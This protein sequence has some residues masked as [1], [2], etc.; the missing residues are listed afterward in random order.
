[1]NA[2]EQLLKVSRRVNWSIG[3]VVE[4]SFQFNYSR[5]FLPEAL[6]AA[7]LPFLSADEQRALNQIRAHG[8]LCLFRLAEEFILPFVLDYA[9]DNRGEDDAETQALLHFAEEE[10]KHIQLFRLFREEFTR[11][12]GTRCDVVGPPQSMA[13]SVLDH[14]ELGVALAVFHIEWMTQRHFVESARDD[15]ALDDHFRSLLKYH[16]LEEAQHTKLDELMIRRIVQRLDAEEIAQ[17]LEDYVRIVTVLDGGLR[18]QVWLDLD[19]LQRASGRQLGDTERS[20]FISEQTR[21]L[22]RTFLVSGMTHP[23]F[24]E[25]IAFMLPSARANIERLARG[26]EASV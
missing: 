25:L 23:K 24:L 6:A 13:R 12:F 4:R 14:S 19:A 11:G 26:F 7:E 5:C 16:W 18:Q 15:R 17:G 1:M 22:R 10:V 9:R 2:F 20:A 21:A 8:Y 3:D